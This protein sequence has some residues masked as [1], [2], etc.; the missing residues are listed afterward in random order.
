[1]RFLIAIFVLMTSLNAAEI[2]IGRGTAKP[3]VNDWGEGTKLKI[4]NFCSLASDSWILNELQEK[5][6]LHCREPSDI[7]EHLPTLRNL[8]KEC[9]SVVEIGIRA[10]VSSWGC[11]LGLSEN[12]SFSRSYLGIDIDSPPH[13]TLNLAKCLAECN[14]ISFDFLQANDMD[15]DI[16][17]TEMLFID[18]LHTYCHLTYELEKFS[19]KVSK[20]IAMHDTST[21]FE[22]IDDNGYYG[23]YSEYPPEYDRTKRGL[24]PAIEDFL[25]KHPEWT[26]HQRNF[27]NYG[28]TVLTRTVSSIAE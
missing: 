1:M 8:A 16:E 26:L 14:G 18:S 3:N 20:Y 22:T 15:I 24:W 27:N 9:S 10:M 28:L 4:G 23:N 5:Y 11:L 13:D 7:N 17:P 21:S 12:P 6:E 25:Q 19:P 2:E